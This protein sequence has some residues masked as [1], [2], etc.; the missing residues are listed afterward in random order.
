MGTYAP[1]LF[2]TRSQELIAT[3]IEIEAIKEQQK[4][5]EEVKAQ[6]EQLIQRIEAFEAAG[7]G[8]ETAFVDS[9]SSVLSLFANVVVTTL[10]I[11]F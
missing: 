8:K 11:I 9:I 3:T 7:K 4:E 1:R 6:N 5:I 2:K 10:R